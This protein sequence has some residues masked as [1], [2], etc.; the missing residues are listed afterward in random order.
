MRFEVRA[1]LGSGDTINYN[2]RIDRK[3]RSA[4]RSR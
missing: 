3:E 1:L 2:E 4:G